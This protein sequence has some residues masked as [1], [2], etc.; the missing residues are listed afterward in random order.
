M[1]DRAELGMYVQT[2]SRWNM[3]RL[4]PNAAAE[5]SGQSRATIT[6]AIAAGELAATKHRS[7]WSIDLDDLDQWTAQRPVSAGRGA[8]GRFRKG[9]VP[10]TPQ[11][12]LR[13]AESAVEGRNGSDA[14]RDR[15]EALEALCGALRAEIEEL[16]GQVQELAAGGASLP[17]ASAPGAKRRLWPFSAKS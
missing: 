9:E 13:A 15:L 16:R 14:V 7:R 12:P 6:R 2:C 3:T 4:T 17:A 10:A 1:H 5:R 8:D 11:M